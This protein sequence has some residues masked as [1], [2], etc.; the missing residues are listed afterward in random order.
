MYHINKKG[1]GGVQKTPMAFFEHLTPAFF[2]RYK[3]EGFITAPLVYPL[4]NH[5]QHPAITECSRF[6]SGFEHFPLW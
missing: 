4:A 3:N 6:G 5:R 2:R 1:E